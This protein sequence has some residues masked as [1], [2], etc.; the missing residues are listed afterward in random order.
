MRKTLLTIFSAL[1]LSGAPAAYAQQAPLRV[2]LAEYRAGR[3]DATTLAAMRLT[4]SQYERLLSINIERAS[5]LPTASTGRYMHIDLA[6]QKLWLYDGG[7]VIHS[8]SVI[9][10][11]PST[12]TPTMVTTISH[13]VLSPYWNVPWD[14]ARDAYAPR[15]LKRGTSYLR[16]LRIEA[17][18]N[19]SDDAK[20]IPLESVNWADVAAGRKKQRLRQLPGY[21]NFMGEMKFI[22]PNTKDIYLHDTPNKGRFAVAS[23]AFSNGCIRLSDAR[24]LAQALLGTVPT[25]PTAEYKVAVPGEVPV[26]ITYLTLQPGADGA[27]MYYKDVYGWDSY[28]RRDMKMA[29]TGAPTVGS[30]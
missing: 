29:I 28:N 11:K 25:P 20:V 5:V 15:V 22:I 12:P 30:N 19:W 6:A 3:T 7:R 24:G 2:A 17:L 10:G 4:P 1:A 14:M 27:L 21:G 23:R 26:Y 8:Q 9:V 16:D 18:T 13:V